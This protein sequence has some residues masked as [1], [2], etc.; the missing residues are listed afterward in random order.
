MAPRRRFVVLHVDPVTHRTIGASP[1][2]D[3]LVKARA[4]FDLYVRTSRP[5]AAIVM[6]DGRGQPVQQT[7]NLHWPS[8]RNRA[9]NPARTRARA[10]LLEARDK[11]R[12]LRERKR[13]DRPSLRAV[14]RA[15]ATQRI[16]A[17]IE[18]LRGT[19]QKIRA[20]FS[21]RR[22]ELAAEQKAAIADARARHRLNLQA[23]RAEVRDRDAKRWAELA[24]LRRAVAEK[25]S[26]LASL[27][28]EKRIK[29]GRRAA[30][31]FQEA[32]AVAEYNVEGSRPDLLIAWK[33]FRKSRGGTKR[34]R[35]WYKAGKAR[36]RKGAARSAAGETIGESFVEYA[37]E[38]PDVLSSAYEAE[39][40]ATERA[41]REH[42]ARQAD[43]YEAAERYAIEHEGEYK[44]DPSLYADEVPF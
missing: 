21:R 19:L 26:I 5:G 14:D 29:A 2:L 27:A 28:S 40:R 6:L 34:L 13:A 7:A 16:G 38:N 24:E 39:E 35:E 44:Y 30:E 41:Q 17:A 32:L 1:W 4:L 9:G 23:I 33:H 12:E 20:E 42:Y 8:N 15:E 43:D 10:E 3:S 22:A 11:L 31:P 18:K 37:D 36:L 25:R